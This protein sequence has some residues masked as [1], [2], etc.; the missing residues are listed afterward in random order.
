M[1]VRYDSISKHLRKQRFEKIKI[2]KL[3]TSKKDYDNII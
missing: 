3:L 2:K 1:R